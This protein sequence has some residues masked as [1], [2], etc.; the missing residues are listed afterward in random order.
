MCYFLWLQKEKARQEKP[1][2]GEIMMGNEGSW[3]PSRTFWLFWLSCLPKISAFCSVNG[4]LFCAKANARSLL[5]RRTAVKA[6]TRVHLPCL[7]LCV[8]SP[9]HTFSAHMALTDESGDGDSSSAAYLGK[10]LWSPTDFTVWKYFLLH[11]INC[12]FQFNPVVLNYL[13]R[14]L[15]WVKPS[16]CG[17]FTAVGEPVLWEASGCENFLPEGG[18]SMWFTFPPSQ[19]CTGAGQTSLAL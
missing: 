6:K 14:V 7:S 18:V 16:L 9:H 13:T 17:H 15:P 3:V 19:F 2:Q 12:L 8:C 11:N 5:L 10:V 4:I 1:T